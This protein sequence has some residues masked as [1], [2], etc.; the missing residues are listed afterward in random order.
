MNRA[1]GMLRLAALSAGGEWGA[2]TYKCVGGKL[3]SGEASSPT[4]KAARLMPS[5]PALA[6]CFPR[7]EQFYIART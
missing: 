1:A 4:N 7:V 5:G 6:R 3:V 2:A